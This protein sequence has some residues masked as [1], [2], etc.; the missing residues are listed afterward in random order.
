MIPTENLKSRASSARLFKSM[1]HRSAGGAAEL[2]ET[3]SQA[4]RCRPEWPR[5][6]SAKP[7]P[8]W[9]SRGGRLGIEMAAGVPDF[10][11]RCGGLTAFLD[12]SEGCSIPVAAIPPPPRSRGVFS[13]VNNHFRLT[14]EFTNAPV[15][16]RPQQP[17]KDEMD[18]KVGRK[19]CDEIAPPV[20]T[21]RRLWHSRRSQ[22]LCKQLRSSNSR[23]KCPASYGLQAVVHRRLLGRPWAI[24]I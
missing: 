17:Q 22:G 3:P 14:S 2:I 11:P 21:F 18:E 6:T 9:L 16:S 8:I 19:G 12:D 1:E 13:F 20:A 7:S 5:P 15:A 4:P 10:V 23:P 24:S